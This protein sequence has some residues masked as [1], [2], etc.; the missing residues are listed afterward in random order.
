MK[1]LLPKPLIKRFQLLERKFDK[2]PEI[3]NLYKKQISEYIELE[4]GR[5]LKME[6]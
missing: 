5:Q 4:H 2:N 1:H 6:E 3:G